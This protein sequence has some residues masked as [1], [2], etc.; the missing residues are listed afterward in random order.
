[1]KFAVVLLATSALLFAGACS[2]KTDENV[3]KIG[4]F[5]PMT[6]ANASGGAQEAEGMELAAK[7]RPTVTVGG[8]EY[9]VQFVLLDNKSDKIEA[10]NAAQRLVGEGV[11]VILGSWGSSLSMA[12]GDIV[13]DGKVPTIGATCTNP[14]V[15]KDNPW[16]F[17]ICFID[18]FQGNVMARYA[19]NTLK[20]KTAAIF[21][22]VSND[23]SV[24]LAKFFV[25]AFTK[26]GGTIVTT[27]NYNTKDQEFS[28]QLGEIKKAAPDVVF[29]P[30]NFTESALIIQ[31]A[32]QLGITA[33]FIGGDT[34][35]TPVFITTG[36][37]SVEG[38]TFSSFYDASATTSDEAK[39]F[40]EDYKQYRN[41][42]P[43]HQKEGVEDDSIPSANAALG[44][45]AY[46]FALDAL[47]AAGTVTD[48]QKIR[49]TIANDMKGWVGATGITTLDENGDA[50]KSAYIKTVKDGKF[51][52][53]TIVNPE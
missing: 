53:M 28:A 34:W 27:V 36:G 51:Q 52:F 47:I 40:V 11:K 1:M 35:E 12:A 20:A 7:L 43:H 45:D 18:P 13:R 41:E 4:A 29:A 32:R 3:V 21:Q 15:T 37:K 25:D 38:A 44:Y 42:L 30:G 39:K 26:A 17:R 22:E 49:D 9:K 6:G 2:K 31:Q 33:P 24:G 10:A 5:E 8:K 50:T 48:T 46:N 23:Y 14:L 19:L 16:Y